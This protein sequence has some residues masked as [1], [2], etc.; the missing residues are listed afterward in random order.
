MSKPILILFNL[1]TL[2][3][4][5]TPV[6]AGSPAPLDQSSENGFFSDLMTIGGLLGIAFVWL[7]VTALE[8]REGYKNLSRRQSLGRPIVKRPARR[9]KSALA[10]AVKAGWGYYRGT[11]RNI[12][13]AGRAYKEVRNDYRASKTFAQGIGS[14][15]ARLL[16]KKKEGGKA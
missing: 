1:L 5:I 10:G 8:P 14:K 15:A 3:M 16:K 6:A 9:K 2:F 13:G 11:K 12:K 7:F 4:L